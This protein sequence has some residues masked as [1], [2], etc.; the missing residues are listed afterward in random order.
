MVSLSEAL[1]TIETGRQRTGR[2]CGSC[3]ECCR[4]IGVEE[5]AKPAGQWCTHCDPG[6]GCR[7]Y[8]ER[9]DLP[10]L[11]V[12]MAGQSGVRRALAADGGAHGDPGGW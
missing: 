2:S 6:H 10:G 11:F 7:I 1:I 12:P 5:L 3:S 9:P 4:L 8:P